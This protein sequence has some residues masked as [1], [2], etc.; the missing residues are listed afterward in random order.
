MPKVV[1]NDT[2]KMHYILT[3]HLTVLGPISGVVVNVSG[4]KLKCVGLRL[5]SRFSLPSPCFG[6]EMVF[7]LR[8][9]LSLS[10]T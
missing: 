5:E 7:E 3:I 2:I 1:P 4:F 9:R 6:W 10:N 8:M